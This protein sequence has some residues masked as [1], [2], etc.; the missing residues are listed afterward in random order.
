VSVARHYGGSTL[1][2]EVK[3]ERG[4]K[5][6][7]LVRGVESRGTADICMALVSQDCFGRGRGREYAYVA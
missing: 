6:T 2:K 1:K 5:K 3:K 4:K 7:L